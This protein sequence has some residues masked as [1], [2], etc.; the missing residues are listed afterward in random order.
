[1]LLPPNT[2]IGAR[3]TIQAFCDVYDLDMSIRDKFHAHGF[4]N[5]DV[6]YLV[7]LSDLKEM[8]FKVGEIAELQNAVRQWAVAL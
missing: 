3:I 4:K 6:F 1:M 2:N 8:E 7:K 5:A